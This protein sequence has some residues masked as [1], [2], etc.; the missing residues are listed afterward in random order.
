M[1]VTVEAN[2]S[3]VIASSSQNIQVANAV[4]QCHDDLDAAAAAAAAAAAVGALTSTLAHGLWRDSG[5]L[6]VDMLQ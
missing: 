2:R 3:E 1:E 4:T 6:V 5:Y